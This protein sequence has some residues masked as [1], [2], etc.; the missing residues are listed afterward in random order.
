MILNPMQKAAGKA[1]QQ[2]Q[3][4]LLLSPTGSGKTLAYLLPL[5]A[6]IDTHLD[7]LQAVVVVPSR[8]LAAQVESVLKAQ[9]DHDVRGLSL[10]GGRPAMEEHRRIKEVHPHVIFATPGRLLDHLGKGN[11]NVLGVKMLVLDEYDK[12]LELGFREEMHRIGVELDFVPQVVVASATAFQDESDDVWKEQRK[13]RGQERQATKLL[14]V[15]KLIA[16]RKF[17]AVD[18]LNTADELSN[19]LSVCEV[20]S[21]QKDKL[22]TL[23]QL[24]SFIGNESTI[25]FVAHRESVER[26]WQNLRT[27]GFSVAMYHG[28]Q[29]QEV[30]ERSL[31]RF[32]AGAANI[33]VSTDLA[34]RG[35]DIPEVRAIIHYHLP[36]DEATFAH[37][38]GRT[39][40]WD[41]EGTAYLLVGPEEKMPDFVRSD[42]SLTV[43]QVKI[44]P[45][46][47]S[48]TVLYIG[49]GKKDKLSKADV[50]GF[51]CKKG[52][53][54]AAQI[55]RI[56]VASHASYVAVQRTS[57]KHL[58]QQIGGEKIKGMK[59]IIEEM[60]AQ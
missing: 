35:L 39:A 19:R 42:K 40:R 9:K 10:Y 51:L 21:P 27:A 32:R 26:V 37:R 56:D 41:A 49:R 31:Y 60:R 7:V 53:L 6:T 4:V 2:K 34:A 13:A 36:Q 22:T 8:E 15:P 48:L 3:N 45:Q 17:A 44:M 14:P 59:T 54:T 55:G 43:D 47:S 23:A 33:L 5:I 50:L 30:R 46:P 38:S 11:V 24:L 58:L 57:V 20:K 1:I 18:F 52:G 16:A 28:G 29:E 25:V 12:C